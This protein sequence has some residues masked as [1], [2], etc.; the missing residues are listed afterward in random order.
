LLLDGI[1]FFTINLFAALVFFPEFEGGVLYFWSE[2][3]LE[4]EEVEEAEVEEEDGI[5]KIE[6]TDFCCDP[7]LAT[8]M[9]CNLVSTAE[10][11][12]FFA[13]SLV[14]SFFY[15]VEFFIIHQLFFD[16]TL[17]SLSSTLNTPSPFTLVFISTWSSGLQHSKL[18]FCA[19]FLHQWNDRFN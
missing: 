18:R 8:F 9:I 17:Y 2:A 10:I 3:E 19:F 15:H 5:S 16:T 13:L 6:A 4:E 7:A 12:I 1:A 11:V 14:P